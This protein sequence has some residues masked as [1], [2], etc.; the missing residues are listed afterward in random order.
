MDEYGFVNDLD[1]AKSILIMYFSNK[2]TLEREL[3]T[4]IKNELVEIEGGF[5]FINSDGYYHF[6]GPDQMDGYVIRE[7]EGW[8]KEYKEISE[9]DSDLM[10]NW[11][12]KL[13][14]VFYEIEGELKCFVLSEFD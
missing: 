12:N 5:T 14:V 3:V 6:G 9:G 10:L 2:F 13:D 4:K 8:L 1:L 7:L 11:L